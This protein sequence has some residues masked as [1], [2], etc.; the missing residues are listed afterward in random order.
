MNRDE[1]LERLVTLFLTID[2]SQSVYIGYDLESIE[3]IA[4]ISRNKQKVA[5][6][7]NRVKKQY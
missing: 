3:N 6:A 5:Q 4:E 7:D 1:F 2:V